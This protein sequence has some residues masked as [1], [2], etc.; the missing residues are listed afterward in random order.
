FH[1]RVVERRAVLLSVRR[2]GLSNELVDF[3]PREEE[4][5]ARHST[6]KRRP[7]YRDR[8]RGA[9]KDDEA[10]RPLGIDPRVA[11]GRRRHCATEFPE[12]LFMRI[13]FREQKPTQEMMQPR[14]SG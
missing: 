8:L 10:S 11:I 6:P 4:A 14:I 12:C 9:T 7:Q 13:G 1:D 5:G 2:E 3:G